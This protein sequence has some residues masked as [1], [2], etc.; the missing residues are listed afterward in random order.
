MVA[1]PVR[2]DWLRNGPVIRPR[3]WKQRVNQ[4]ESER[5]VEAMRRSV[6][7]GAPC[8]SDRWVKLTAKRLGLEFSIRPRGRPRNQQKT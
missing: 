3:N 6:N 7:R 1:S 4:A 8:G 5:E 2:Q